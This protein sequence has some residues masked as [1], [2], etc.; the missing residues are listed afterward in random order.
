MPDNVIKHITTPDGTTYDVRDD[1]KIETSL[2]G[3]ANGVATLGSDSKLPSSQLPLATNGARGGV[4]IGYSET[5]RNYALKLASEKGYVTVPEIANTEYKGDIDDLLTAGRY[6]LGG[7]SCTTENLTSKFGTLLVLANA[8][9]TGTR[10]TQVYIDMFSD[11]SWYRRYNGSWQPIQ[12]IVKQGDIYNEL[13]RTTAGAALDAR[14]GKILNDAIAGKVSGPASATDGTIPLFDGATGKAIKAGKTITDVTTSTAM[15]NNANMPTN[16]TVY[17]AIYN[18]LDKT[19]AGFALDARQGKALNDLFAKREYQTY[20]DVTTLGLTEGSATILSAFRAMPTGSVLIAPSYSFADSELPKIGT[21]A[22]TSVTITI[23][24]TSSAARSTVSARTKDATAE[25]EMG[26]S[27]STYNGNNA[28]EPNGS[29]I[30]I[31]RLNMNPE[32]S[33]DID[34]LLKPGIYYVGGAT[35]STFS[36]TLYGTLLVWGNSWDNANGNRVTQ[37]Y[38][39]AGS[40]GCWQRRYTGSWQKRNNLYQPM[41]FL[42]SA[43]TATLTFPAACSFTVRTFRAGTTQTG[44][45][46]FYFGF[47]GTSNSVLIPILTPSAGVTLSINNL[48]LTMTT[49]ASN[50]GMVVDYEFRE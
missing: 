42:A 37:L 5:G 2:M 20:K 41:Q 6:Y 39:G 16:R 3:A 13:N 32:F 9:G 44:A 18:G 22:Q 36:G 8:N 17:N 43:G 29:W 31:N 38:I 45:F 28:N 11:T 23:K 15:A 34:T 19:A 12:T 14:Q 30:R 35:S 49:S 27:G 7:A 26:L 1:N 46:G 48:V 40:I 50:V 47:A 21:T 33:G 24:K 4:Q 25:W 10:V